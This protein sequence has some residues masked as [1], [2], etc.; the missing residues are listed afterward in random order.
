MISALALGI[1]LGG[2]RVLRL[3]LLAVVLAVATYLRR[4]GPR[5][6]GAGM[7]MFMGIFFGFFLAGAVTIGDLGW[8]SAAIGV[9]V[10]VALAVR[11]AFFYPHHAKAVVGIAGTVVGIGIGSLV[12]DAVGHDTY[13]SVAAILVSL[14]SAST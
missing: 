8:L 10:V 14:F 7:L 9:G 3:T 2:D 13:W 11:F 1:V 5:G 12:V 4:F 6:M